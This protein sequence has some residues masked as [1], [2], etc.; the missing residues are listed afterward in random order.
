MIIITIDSS[1]KWDHF[2]HF[3]LNLLEPRSRIFP[4]FGVEPHSQVSS[5]LYNYRYQ[6]T[7]HKYLPVSRSRLIRRCFLRRSRKLSWSRKRSLLTIH[8]V[9]FAFLWYWILRYDSNK[10]SCFWQICL[11][12][13]LFCYFV[14]ST[15]RTFIIMWSKKVF[16]IHLLHLS[17]ESQKE[18]LL[19]HK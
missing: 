8:F 19:G 6:S 2:H 1:T 4:L 12:S 17:S 13:L 18:C 15:P 10:K 3:F 11:L 9:L 5:L 16:S 14:F 7:K